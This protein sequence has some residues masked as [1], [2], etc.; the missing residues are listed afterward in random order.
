MRPS[1]LRLYPADYRC[2]HGDEIAEVYGETVRDAPASVRY[3][4]T[5]DIAGHALRLRLGL[6]S[7]GRPA[8]LV[9]TAAPFALAASAA[10]SAAYITGWYVGARAGAQQPVFHLHPQL[11]ALMACHLVVLVGAVTAL[12]S[13]WLPGVLL[14]AAGLTL[15]TGTSLAVGP[16][17]A[18]PVGL[19]AVMAALTAVIVL[20]CPPDLRP[21][22][23]T[24]ALA[25]AAAAVAWLP[26]AALY[27]HLLPITTDYGAWPF[28]VLAA[29]GAGTAL[30][31]R[32]SGLLHLAAMALAAA[33]F[34]ALSASVW[35][36]A[37]PVLA[38]WALIPL[39]AVPTY[40]L[41]LLR[42]GRTPAL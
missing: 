34:V 7:A 5:L 13:R 22:P 8:E 36:S 40:A 2:T 17:H 3:R 15:L 6:G 18:D 30:A 26:L 1:V 9:A 4:E 16:V 23:S 35:G 28:L 14:T 24:R 32:S 29:T 33:P 27:A 41:H 12:A 31:A 25:G 39:A 21:A 11:T 42:G 10:W 20:G 38:G 37:L 19:T